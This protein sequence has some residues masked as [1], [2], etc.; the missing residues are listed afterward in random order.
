MFDHRSRNLTSVFGN[1]IT[2]A[3]G[4]VAGGEKLRL[5]NIDKTKHLSLLTDWVRVLQRLKKQTH[6]PVTTPKNVHVV[7]LFLP[8]KC[9]GPISKP[10]F[11]GE[12]LRELQHSAPCLQ[13]E[14]REKSATLKKRNSPG[15]HGP[16]ISTCR[17]KE[18]QK[19]FEYR[20]SDYV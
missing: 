2:I 6:A 4:H 17:T 11:K 18:Q 5:S 8:H 10:M 16:H 20:G 14:R 7:T 1:E 9:V 19:Q 15:N 12:S 3:V 13:C